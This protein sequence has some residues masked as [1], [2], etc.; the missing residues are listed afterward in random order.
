[1][2]VAAIAFL[3]L[4]DFPDTA[5]FLTEEERAFVVY[6]LKYQGQSDDPNQAQIAQ[7]DEFKWK[8]VKD[9][10]LDWQIWVNIFVYWG[11]SVSPL[12]EYLGKA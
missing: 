6:R 2:I 11:V 7:A 1:V 10:F 9:A 3:A 4:H 12:S 5:N 8:Y